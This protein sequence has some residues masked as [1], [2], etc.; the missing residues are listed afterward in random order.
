[1]LEPSRTTILAAYVIY[2]LHGFS[3][4][5]GLLSSAFIVTAFL[6]GWPS[7]LALLLTYLKRGDARHSYLESHYDWLLG[8]FWW[9]LI[10]ICLSGVLFVTFIGIPFA[11]LLLIGTGLWVLYRLFHGGSRLL[12]G[13][14]V[15]L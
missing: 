15:D 2:G 7:I 12:N 6:T 8:T 1:M 13:R 4:I 11:Y 3:A 14:G 10:G 5:N 9:S